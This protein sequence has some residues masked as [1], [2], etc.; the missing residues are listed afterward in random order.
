MKVLVN[1]LKNAVSVPVILIGQLG[2]DKQHSHEIRGSDLLNSCMSY[3]YMTHSL[4]GSRVV[5]VETIK[6]EKVIA[7]YHSWMIRQGRPHQHH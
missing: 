5:L 6:C 3:V 4:V 7:F 2:K 1:D